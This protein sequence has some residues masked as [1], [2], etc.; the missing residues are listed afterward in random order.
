MLKKTAG[1]TVKLQIRVNI[2]ITIWKELFEFSTF[3]EEANKMERCNLNDVEGLKLSY[4]LSRF[5]R[6]R[7][8][9]VFPARIC[10]GG[11]GIM[12]YIRPYISQFTSTLYVS[13]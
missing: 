4:G 9:P 10:C 3:N 2:V 7:F 8:M 11:R 12:Y 5:R 1:T 6:G 13:I